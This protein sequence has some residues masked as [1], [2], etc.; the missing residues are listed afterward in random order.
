MFRRQGI[1]ARLLAAA[2][3]V[4]TTAGAARA[5]S[6]IDA[7]GTAT[8]PFADSGAPSSSTHNVWISQD[9]QD[10]R[11]TLEQLSAPFQGAT[12]PAAPFQYQM[13]WNTSTAPP[14]LEVY[15]GS[16]WVVTAYLDTTAHSWTPVPTLGGGN[17]LVSAANALLPSAR[18]NLLAA[19]V[20]NARDTTYAGG[21]K[22]DNAT[23]DSAALQAAIT[24]AAPIGGAVV[25][26]GSAATTPA[27]CLLSA[28]VQMA[29]GTSL[30]ATPGTVILKQKTGNTTGLIGATNVSNVYVFGV[31]VDGGGKDFA[32]ANNLT[33]IFGGGTPAD[34]VVFD[35]V[36]F[37]HSRGIAMEASTS[38]TNSGVINSYFTDIGN[39][40]KTTALTADR[41]QALAFCCGTTANSHGNFA[42]NNY[43]EDI[44]L[45]AISAGHQ[46]DF[47][48]SGNV[49]SL[50]DGQITAVWNNP[51][52]VAFGA[53]IY[54]TTNDAMNILNNRSSG[55]Q[56]NAID[57]ASVTDRVI[58]GNH[59]D[60]S[61]DTGIG[62]F[63]SGNAVISG[64]ISKNGGQ[65][66]GAAAAN[67]GSGI[68]LNGALGLVSVSGNDLLDDQAG[69]TQQYGVFGKSGVTFTE[70]DIDSSN[71]T[72]GNVHGRF[73][74]TLPGYA[75]PLT[76]VPVYSSS[77]GTNVSQ[78]TSNASYT[79]NNSSRQVCWS[80][81]DHL[82]ATGGPNSIS[83]TLPTVPASGVA[84][85]G[86]GVESNGSNALSVTNSGQTVTV[87]SVSG[88]AV[89]NGT[90]TFLGLN[91]CYISG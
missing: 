73:G 31:T 23:D 29:A 49:C 51:Q 40:W 39:H 54:G 59:L 3:L 10:K 44:G 82:T 14:Q 6:T 30:I 76:W 35:R 74:G 88:G 83:F 71:A 1:A 77:G 32:V 63:S 68:G 91:G 45:D 28:A 64:N 52:P 72:T 24:A 47:D 58:V 42:R 89:P 7:L 70:L 5:A 18:V 26:T 50:A 17:M 33:G 80:L 61:G 90:G 19:P 21:M 9:G 16:Q 60:L 43:F 67:G 86:S 15:D 65:W 48:A 38:V 22:C 2:C 56:G 12:A 87:R 57:T 79:I 85:T 4:L 55:A 84:A 25:I 8:F 53:C 66:A 41:Q 34:N 13:W 62:V 20:I 81:V 46:H 78:T 36:R 69:A 27:T 37:Q 11:A 75:A